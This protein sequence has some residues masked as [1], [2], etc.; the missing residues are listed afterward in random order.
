MEQNANDGKM[1]SFYKEQKVAPVSQNI[2]DLR[3]HFHRRSTLYKQMGIIP[4]DF[5]GK[6]IIE[7]G[8][9][10]GQNSLFLAYLKPQSLT[11][12]EPNPTGIEKINEVFQL[13]GSLQNPI[14]EHSEIET[15]TSTEKYDYVICEGLVGASGHPDPTTLI[16]SI[17]SHTKPGGMVI[18]TSID[19]PAYSSE[20]IRRLIGFELTKSMDDFDAKVSLLCDVFEPHLRNLTG[21]TRLSKDWVIDNLLNPASV[22]TLMSFSELISCMSNL[23]F[24]TVGTSPRFIADWAWYK[25][26]ALEPDFFNR[27]AL[28]SY[29]PCAH[30]FMDYCNIYPNRTEESNRQ[31]ERDCRKIHD[32]IRLYEESNDPSI[33][34]ALVQ[35]IY[36]LIQSIKKDMPFVASALREVHSWLSGENLDPA[37]IKTST[38]FGSWFG[39][40]QTYVAFTS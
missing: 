17:A 20:M 33:R 24:S 27:S 18:L 21:M 22:S 10:T 36:S 19:Y 9:G 6:R 2:D 7:I 37:V 28:R 25:D 31:L 34:A 1:L 3:Q 26:A 14:I 23:G 13:H 12:V 40:S 5:F 11:L 35:N 8:P 4:S 15:F 39:R 29:W 30:G 38:L 32:G 16:A